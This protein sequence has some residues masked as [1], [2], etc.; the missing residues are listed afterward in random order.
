MNPANNRMIVDYVAEVVAKE[1]PG[2]QPLR[3]LDLGT[4][5]GDMVQRLRHRFPQLESCGVDY[6][7]EQFTLDVPVQHADLNTD[8]LPYDGGSFDLVTCTEVVEH[9]ENYRHAIREAA[10][11]LKPGGVL[12]LSTPNVLSLKSRWAFLTRGFFTYFNPLPLKEDPKTYPAQR[13]ITP[14]PFFHLG[15]TLLDAGFTQ[16]KPHRDKVQRSSGFWAVLLG[17]FLRS[18][19]RRSRRRLTRRYWALPEAVEELARLNN[20]WLILTTRTLIVT[21]RKRNDR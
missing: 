5:P 6:H 19:S 15:H 1:I 8:R 4:G 9:L 21:A 12:V 18:A 10:R 14:V 7:P 3:H 13:H 11:L 20:S 16:I 2:D 17:P